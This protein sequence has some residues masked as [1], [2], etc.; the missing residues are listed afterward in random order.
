MFAYI[1]NGALWEFHIWNC[2]ALQKVNSNI[3]INTASLHLACPSRCTGSLFISFLCFSLG[4]SGQT[5]LKL[6]SGRYGIEF[7]LICIPI[8]C[9]TYLYF[10][11]ASR[12]HKH[13]SS[14]SYPSS[15]P[16][17]SLPSILDP[18]SA[19]LGLRITRLLH[20]LTTKIVSYTHTYTHTCPWSP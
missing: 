6:P 2:K 14:P 17:S 4:Y 1:F 7:F 8:A 9:P 13:A 20:C 16:P 18:P 15:P 10:M 5:S 12:G 3:N 19:F 11:L